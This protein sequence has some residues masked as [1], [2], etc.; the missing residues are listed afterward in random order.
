MWIR[1]YFLLSRFFDVNFKYDDTKKFSYFFMQAI[2]WIIKK[3]SLCLFVF[4]TSSHLS[5]Y[6]NSTLQT[7]YKREELKFIFF[8]KFP[9]CVCTALLIVVTFMVD[10]WIFSLRSGTQDVDG[11]RQWDKNLLSHSA[12]SVIRT[13][14]M[15]LKCENWNLH[16]MDDD[17]ILWEHPKVLRSGK[18]LLR[19]T[20]RLVL[21]TGMRCKSTHLLF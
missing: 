20:F 14:I 3:S 2:K 10:N 11:R 21:A 8:E 17:K 15:Q 9:H 18:K 5:Y 4:L 13:W 19:L 1:K 12:K 16:S 7:I 6:F